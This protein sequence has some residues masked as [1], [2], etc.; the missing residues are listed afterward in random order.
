[1]RARGS[2]L[3]CRL[4]RGALILACIANAAAEDESQRRN[5]L[6][7]S[8][9]AVEAGEATFHERCAVCHGQKAEGS[10]ASNL[11]RARSVRRGP[12]S[13]LFALV[14]AG[15]PGTDMPPQ[16]DLS[17]EEIWQ[18]VSYLH[19]LA[20]PG[21]QPPV[22]G[23]VEA[24][25][26]VFRQAG[27]SSCHIVDGSGGFFG[28]PLDALATRKTSAQIRGDVLEPSLE[29]AE[30]YETVVIETRSGQ[31]IEGLLKNEDTF[32]VLILTAAGEPMA[33]RRSALRSVT[34]PERSAMPSDFGAKLSVNQIQNL[35]AYLDRQRDP[36][37]PIRRGFGNY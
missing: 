21:L 8:P 17:A 28:P 11:R 6:G 9:E 18:I 31:R 14:R 20:R 22:E 19:S 30:G 32:E 33:L 29:L 25:K 4:R 37:V 15:I 27:C 1:M 13:D 2:R 10:M 36:F 12:A 16:P 35:L 5:P 26:A 34:K 3:G 23:D 24:G 7:R